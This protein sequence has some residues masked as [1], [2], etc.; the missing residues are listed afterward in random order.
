MK[1]ERKEGKKEGSTCTNLNNPGSSNQ[2]QILTNLNTEDFKLLF[3]R[4]A[5]FSL[6]SFQ[7]FC[8][9]WPFLA[10]F[11]FGG[12]KRFSRNL[13]GKKNPKEWKEAIWSFPPIC[14]H[15][16]LG[17]VILPPHPIPLPTLLFLPNAPFLNF[18]S[19]YIWLPKINS[20]HFKIL[21]LPGKW[22]DRPGLMPYHHYF[23]KGNFTE[24]QF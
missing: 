23:F 14:R 1:R 5:A 7:L 6:F 3:C 8:F 2:N 16:S 13:M 12:L 18:S 15:L 24:S 19:R 4:F 10:F 22:N 9:Y 17:I 20:P 11:P 21:H